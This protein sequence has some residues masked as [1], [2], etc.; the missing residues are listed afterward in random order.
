M[1][2][3]FAYYNADMSEMRFENPGEEYG[4]PPTSSSFDTLGAM[5]K[6]G[7]VSTREE[8]Q[9]ALIS[10]TVFAFIGATFFFFWGTG[11]SAPPPPPIGN[12]A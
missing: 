11:S 5:V 6:W 1:H 7:L 10:I 2:A 3:R 8:A 9:Y 12:A 4:P